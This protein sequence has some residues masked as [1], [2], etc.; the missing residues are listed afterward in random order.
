MKIIGVVP[1]RYESSRFPGKP[2]LDIKGKSMISRVFHTASQCHQI[3][4]VWIATDDSRI[5]AHCS[6]RKIPVVMTSTDHRSGTD[7]VAEVA[8]SKHADV[9]INIQG[10]EP[11]LPSAH[12][13][14][15]V[16]AFADETVQI[17]TLA[18]PIKDETLMSN[19]NLVKLVKRADGRA[20]YFS[21]SL[22]PFARGKSELSNYWQHLGVY[23]Y[24]R[25]TLLALSNL[26][27]SWLESMEKLEQLRWLESGYDVQVCEVSEGTIGIDHL[28]DVDRLVE[29]M[30][31]NGVD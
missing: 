2:L 5:F 23:A 10:D 9:I 17:A 25:A 29:W 6:D 28:T 24:R 14:K 31:Q 26:Q 22:I 27:V 8:L 4:E 15:L 1:A 11:F 21:R 18:A 16:A 30:E 20:L 13:D 19:P 12:L 3:D 7:R